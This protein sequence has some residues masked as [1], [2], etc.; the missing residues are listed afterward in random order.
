LSRAD[1]RTAGDGKGR[2]FVGAQCCLEGPGE[3][4]QC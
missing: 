1:N 3:C 2:C 4:R